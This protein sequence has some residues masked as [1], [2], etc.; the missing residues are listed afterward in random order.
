MLSNVSK[1][2]ALQQN[3]ITDWWQAICVMVLVKTACTTRPFYNT[4]NHIYQN[5][6]SWQHDF[7]IVADHVI[8]VFYEGYKERIRSNDEY[9]K[10]KRNT[11]SF[12]AIYQGHFA[13]RHHLQASVRNDRYTDYGSHY[14]QTAY[15]FDLMCVNMG[16]AGSTGFKPAFTIYTDQPIR[17][18]TLATLILNP[19]NLVTLKPT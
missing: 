8:S 14:R 17:V 1:F 6:L 19:K 2:M 16:V 18:I 3:K 5:S 12:G 7:T 15:D 11:N 10:T 4:E 13:N 9:S